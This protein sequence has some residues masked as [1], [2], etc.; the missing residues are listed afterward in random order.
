MSYLAKNYNRKKISFVYGKG[1]YLYSTNKKKY[2]ENF[3][4]FYRKFDSGF[5]HDLLICFKQFKKKNLDEWK[6]ILINKSV[7]FI[8]FNDDYEINDFDI[9][10]YLRVAKKYSDRLILFINTY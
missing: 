2:L 5:D 4:E 8:E 9:G 7:D 10:S 1:S 3:I 6:K